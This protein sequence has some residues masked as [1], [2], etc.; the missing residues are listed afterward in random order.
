MSG[1]IVR[2]T[3]SVASITSSDV[4]VQAWREYGSTTQERR[5]ECRAGVPGRKCLRHVSQHSSSENVETPGTVATNE[6][7]GPGS[8]DRVVLSLSRTRFRRRAELG[9]GS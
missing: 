2:S 3:P 9:T 5:H 1:S 6:K 4:W 7:P 8:P